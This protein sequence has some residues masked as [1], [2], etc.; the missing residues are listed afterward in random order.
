MLSETTQSPEY[1][2]IIKTVAEHLEKKGFEQIKADAETFDTPAK[3]SKQGSE[4]SFTPNLTARKKDGSK[5]Y[6]EVV[7][8]EQED[9]EM[10]LSKWSMLSAFAELREGKFYLIVPNGKLRFTNRL[11]K[12]NEQIHANV[13][14]YKALKTTMI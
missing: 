5:Y 3:M 2:E 11:L 10:L 4:I 13:L 12:E 7:S 6:F 8:K 1:Q 14:Q 9:Q